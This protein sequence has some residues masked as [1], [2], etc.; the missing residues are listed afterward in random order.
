MPDRDPRGWFEA[1]GVAKG[2]C[3]RCASRQFSSHKRSTWVVFARRSADRPIEFRRMLKRHRAAA[4]WGVE[5]RGQGTRSGRDRGPTW[6]CCI[7]SRVDQLALTGIARARDSLDFGNVMCSTPSWK[8]A[9]TLSASTLLG[10]T[11]ER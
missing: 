7:P 6:C 5:I 9:F 10:N 4:S 8:V 3:E 11:T 2:R 1:A